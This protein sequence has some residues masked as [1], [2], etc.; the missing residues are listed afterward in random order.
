MEFDKLI[1][2]RRSMRGYDSTKS[3]T[4]EDIKKLIYS[5]IQAP[6]WKNS[7]T[8]RYYCILSQKKIIFKKLFFR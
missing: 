1:E 3:L 4:Q 6:S 8:G 5:A 7:Q 2:A